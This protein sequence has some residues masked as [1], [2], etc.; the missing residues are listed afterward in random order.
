MEHPE[1]ETYSIRRHAGAGRPAGDERFVERLESLTGC[2][3]GKK[4]PGLEPA[5]K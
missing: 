3:L 1:E 4:K 2:E 5:M